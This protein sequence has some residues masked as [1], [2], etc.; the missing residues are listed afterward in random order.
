[1][2]ILICFIKLENGWFENE[3]ETKYET[4]F[5]TI[6]WPVFDEIE[7]ISD[8]NEPETPPD[9]VDICEDHNVNAK[10]I[11]DTKKEKVVF[12]TRAHL[13]QVQ[14]T[15]C[16]GEIKWKKMPHQ[17]FFQNPLLG[18]Q[19]NVLKGRKKNSAVEAYT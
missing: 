10:C 18:C 15:A 19:W 16:W 6:S 7:V 11:V 1:M 8:N 9:N 4:R 12:T 5:K 14:V 2:Y 13:H 17:K 3:T